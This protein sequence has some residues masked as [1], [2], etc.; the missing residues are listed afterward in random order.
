MVSGTDTAA[1]GIITL[2]GAVNAVPEFKGYKSLTHEAVIA[3]QPDVLLMMDRGGSHGA[4]NEALLAD[5]AIKMTPAGKTKSIIRMDGAYLLGFG[6]RTASA[7]KDLA[8]K[9]YG[10][11]AE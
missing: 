1:D 8:K 4:D 7:I 10:V 5:P 3:A 6:P 2:A 9:L 11:E